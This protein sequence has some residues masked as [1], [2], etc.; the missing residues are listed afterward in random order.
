M[1]EELI[2]HPVLPTWPTPAA[3]I[4]IEEAARLKKVA[5]DLKYDISRYGP[6]NETLDCILKEHKKW[7]ESVVNPTK[8][9]EEEINRT[10][11]YRSYGGPVPKPSKFWKV[12][13]ICQFIVIAIYLFMKLLKG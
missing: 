9:Q 5:E 8:E 10:T 13:A 7:R 4:L 2:K 3:E 1:T 6:L 12:F 11:P